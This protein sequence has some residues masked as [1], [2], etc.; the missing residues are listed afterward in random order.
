MSP[1]SS[2]E[3]SAQLGELGWSEGGDLRGDQCLGDGED[4]VEAQCAGVGHPVLDVEMNLRRDVALCACSRRYE[5]GV[6]DWD[7]GGA[8]QDTAGAA[9]LIGQLVPPDLASVHVARSQGSSR[10]DWRAAQLAPRSS[11]GTWVYD[12][13]IAASISL[14]CSSDVCDCSQSDLCV[15]LG[16]LG[17]FLQQ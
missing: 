14:R 13:M 15:V 1:S 6:E 8:C 4:V 12:S 2:V 17:R 7:G 5:D 16:P 9:V 3:R 11:W 10:I